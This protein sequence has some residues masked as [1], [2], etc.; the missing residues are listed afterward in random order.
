MQDGILENSLAVWHGNSV[1]RYVREIPQLLFGQLST[2][3]LLVQVIYVVLSELVAAGLL[4]PFVYVFYPVVES[5]NAVPVH[6][7]LPAG[8][9]GQVGV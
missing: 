8:Q 1:H 9:P 7:V 5:V 4:F 2:G 3:F 6:L